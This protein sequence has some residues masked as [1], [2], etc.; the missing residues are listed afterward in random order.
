MAEKRD[1]YE[2]LGISKSASP[3]EIKKAYR[4][5]AKKYH[6]DINKEPGAEEKFK[7]VQEAYD[8]L[9]DD[10][11]K[12]LYDQYGWAGVDPQYGG[13][14]GAGFNG[15]F[16]GFDGFSNFGDG[17]GIDLGDIFANMF[18]G[19]RRGSARYNN[20]PSKGQDKFI[21][22]KISFMDSVFG[23]KTEFTINVDV[24]CPNCHGTGAEKPSDIVTCSR[25]NGSGMVYSVQNTIFG[26]V[27]QQTTCPDCR[28]TG[29][30]IKTKCS[31]CGGSGYHTEKKTI[32][33]NIPAGIA[34]HQQLKL[35]GKGDRG[36]NGGQPGNIYVEVIVSEHD[37]FKREGDDIH[38]TIP[39][40]FPDAALGCIVEVPTAYGDVDLTIPAGIQDGQILRI[41]GKG[42]K[43]LRGS[44]SGDQ[45]VH[46]NIKTPTSL[47][48]EQ[49]ELY[50]K[51]REV[52]TDSIFTKL[53]KK[54]KK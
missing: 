42:F 6:P 15:G 12:A 44:N 23:K 47:S 31:Q 34:S 30:T 37:T 11:K 8:I 21:K 49:K 28:G 41:K 50:S 2:V 32:E 19:G 52:E 20:G 51:L 1:I 45:L 39:L 43:S 24:D 33:V 7:E 36:I 26:Q 17:Q 3:D 29:K 18:G 27:R 35:E 25:C 22:T 14:G 13:A 48:K 4:T 53:K 16:G 9:S 54:F 10:K 40:S 38:I 5:L 46:V